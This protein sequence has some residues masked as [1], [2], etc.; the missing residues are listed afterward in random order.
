MKK[1][2]LLFTLLLS[3]SAMASNEVDLYD[4]QGNPVVYIAIDDGMTIYS[5][6][7]QP[8]AYLKRGQN[9][10]FDVY[11]FNGKHLG[12]FI[13]G[14]LIDHDGYAVCGTKESVSMPLLPPL[15]SLKSLKPLKSL[16]ELPPLLPLMKNSFGETDCAS[17]VEAGRS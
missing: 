9:N 13:K 7:G 8:D 11:G 3:V 2:F 1:L 4:T 10:E 5:W 15:K 12:W 6:G 16:P 14:K 17:F